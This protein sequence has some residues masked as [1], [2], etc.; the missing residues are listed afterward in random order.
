[1][2]RVGTPRSI[3]IGVVEEAYNPADAAHFARVQ[4]AL[5]AASAMAHDGAHLADMLLW[6]A[7]GE[8]PRTAGGWALRSRPEFAGPTHCMAMVGLSSGSVGQIDVA[9]LYPGD[10]HAE[11]VMRGPHGIVR[12][13]TV[14][15]REDAPHHARL[16]AQWEDGTSQD[17]EIA[18]ATPHFAAQLDLF[19]DH[20]DAGTVPV[21]G[22]AEA[23][24]SL[25]L[26]QASEEAARK[27]GT[28]AVAQV[29]G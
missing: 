24:R 21:P 11:V 7:A 1:M 4:G 16:M 25:A 18:T 5:S 12:G 20:L 28:V 9:W 19:L 26:T 6:L 8:E 10:L 23:M 14:A 2:P 17:E 22:I 27:G 13:A 29:P 3:R 15:V